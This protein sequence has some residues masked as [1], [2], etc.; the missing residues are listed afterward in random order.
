MLYLTL[1]EKP[2]VLMAALMGGALEASFNNLSQLST[3][4]FLP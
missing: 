2:A 1:Q 3:S 4:I